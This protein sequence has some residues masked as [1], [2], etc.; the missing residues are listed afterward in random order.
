MA[1]GEGLGERVARWQETREFERAKLAILYVG[2]QY[3]PTY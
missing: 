1:G 2:L 3:G